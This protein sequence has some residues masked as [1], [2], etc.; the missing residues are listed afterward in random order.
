M[1]YLDLR[2][3][4]QVL[5]RDVHD[6]T[7]RICVDRASSRVS[8]NFVC[9]I[10][11]SDFAC[12]VMFAPPIGGFLFDRLG[13]RAPFIF[14]IGAAALDLIGRLVV[15]DRKEALKWNVDPV[16]RAIAFQTKSTGA[17]VDSKSLRQIDPTKSSRCRSGSSPDFFR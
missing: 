6:R 4:A 10:A 14:G 11:A 9:K 16:A 8:G 1:R 12:S 15:I 17:T 13:F 7:N 3:E 5:L 2:F